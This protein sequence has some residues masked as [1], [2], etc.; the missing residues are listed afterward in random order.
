MTNQIA[1]LYQR[2]CSS[3]DSSPVISAACETLPTNSH[4]R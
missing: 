3:S 1:A 4:P 2:L